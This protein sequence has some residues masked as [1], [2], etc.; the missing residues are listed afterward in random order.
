MNISVTDLDR[1]YTQCSDLYTLSDKTGSDIISKLETNITNLKNNW[2]GNDAMEH[3]NNLIVVH[4]ALVQLVTNAKK[5]TSAAA[6]AIIDIQDVRRK[7]GGGGTVGEAL[8]ATA[9][10]SQVLTKV[11]PTSEYKCL[12]GAKTDQTT[13]ESLCSE[14]ETFK[15]NFTAKK[16]ELMTNWTAG[17]NREEAVRCFTTFLTSAEDYKKYMTDANSKLLIAVSNLSTL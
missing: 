14:F 8:A 1:S 11:E 17:A 2:I 15:T 4:D 16:D 5:L 6:G 9:P 13:L 12:P 3:I 10:S 7:N